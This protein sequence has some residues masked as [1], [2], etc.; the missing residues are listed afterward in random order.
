MLIRNSIK[1]LMRTPVKTILFLLLITFAAI[2]STV[3][4]NLWQMSA[5]NM[6]AFEA[7]FTTIGTVEQKKTLMKKMELWDAITQTSNYYYR[8]AFSDPIPLT[9][10][11]FEGADYIYEPEKRPF[12]GA[13]LPDYQLR[14]P[15]TNVGLDIIIIEFTV[16]E[17]CVPDHQV[18]I[19]IG[20]QVFTRYQINSPKEWFIDR[21]NPNPEKLYKGKKYIMA[22]METPY[23][24][25]DTTFRSVFTP[26]EMIEST[27]YSK[28]GELLSDDM[29]G[30]LYE[31][32]TD[33][34]Y[35]S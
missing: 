27:Q 12:Y 7:V 35:E 32:V 6:K 4:S 33:G 23:R 3:G 11:D 34:F 22:M 31:E 9:V 28:E 26:V 20:K 29:R 16:D 5:S 15:N 10:L 21:S 2:L 1:Q 18:E 24:T 14:P 8:E 30:V 19:N 17:D 25:S 13:Y